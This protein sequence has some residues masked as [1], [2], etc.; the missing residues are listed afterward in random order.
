MVLGQVMIFN[1]P[2]FVCPFTLLGKIYLRE[3]WSQKFGW[4]DQLPTELRAK[5][6]PFFYS[7]FDLEYLSL[8]RSLPPPNSIGQPWLL[9]FSDGSDL[10]NGFVAFIRWQ[11]DNGDYWSPL[12]IAKCRIAPVNK[13]STPPPPMELNAVVLS[14]RGRKVIEKDMRFNFER[15][16]AHCRLRDYIGHDQQ[17]QHS[18]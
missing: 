4:D 11:L 8:D 1:P 5:W 14:K 6:A 2:G 15:S 3:T 18:F 16:V 9:I 17:D 7:L 12:V 10:T 13:L